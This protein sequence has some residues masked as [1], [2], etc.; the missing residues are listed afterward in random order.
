LVIALASPS[1]SSSSSSSSFSHSYIPPSL[2]LRG[3]RL[4]SL[5]P[6]LLPSSSKEEEGEGVREEGERKPC[7]LALGLN[8]CVQKVSREGGREG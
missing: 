8:P 5:P 2:T 1:S 3:P 7:I 4:L 6:S